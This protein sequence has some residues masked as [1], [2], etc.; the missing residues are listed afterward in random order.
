MDREERM[1]TGGDHELAWGIKDCGCLGIKGVLSSS[2]WGGVETFSIGGG[3][4][5]KASR[6]IE[7][8]LTT[9]NIISR[10]TFTN[11]GKGCWGGGR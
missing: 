5:A 10:I 6:E 7:S 8:P 11:K 1:V 3:T 9:Y 2:V 4:E